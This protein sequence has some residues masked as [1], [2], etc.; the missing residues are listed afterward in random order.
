VLRNKLPLCGGSSS[1]SS[2]PS[3]KSPSL[4]LPLAGNCRLS[5]DGL[6]LRFRPRGAFWPRGWPNSPPPVLEVVL[7]GALPYCK[8]LFACRLSGVNGEP[9]AI[10][11]ESMMNLWAMV[12]SDAALSA[13]PT[14]CSY[15][16]Q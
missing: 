14:E 6:P 4:S 3:P 7:V 1:S 12:R 2:K 10:G 16:W 13:G 15:Q 9:L 8:K 5:P 11:L